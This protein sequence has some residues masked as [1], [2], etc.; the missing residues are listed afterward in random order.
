MI[1]TKQGHPLLRRT[2]SS[3]RGC[4]FALRRIIQI[5]CLVENHLGFCYFLVIFCHQRCALFAHLT[6]DREEERNVLYIFI[7]NV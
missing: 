1:L 2:I 4:T 3:Y 6:N 7:K 5:N